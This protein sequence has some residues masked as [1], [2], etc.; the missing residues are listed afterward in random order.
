MTPSLSADLA[1]V[2]G[3]LGRPYSPAHSTDKAARLLSPLP[4]PVRWCLIPQ[5]QDHV[6]VAPKCNGAS[7]DNVVGTVVSQVSISVPVRVK[8]QDTNARPRG[9]ITGA[10]GELCTFISVVCSLIGQ[11]R[12]PLPSS[13]EGPVS[14]FPLR[15]TAHQA[16]TFLGA[17]TRPS[18]GAP[19]CCRRGHRYCRH[20]AVPRPV[21][22]PSSAPLGPSARSPPPPQLCS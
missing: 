17:I 15:V 19:L 14:R 4:A 3:S 21:S 12:R 8:S 1:G 7:L 18:S 6:R 13:Q 5:S 2:T 9:V 10:C 16:S 22:P 11:I 20:L